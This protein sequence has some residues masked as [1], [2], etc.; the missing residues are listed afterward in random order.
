MA[1]LEFTDE[2]FDQVRREA[3]QLFFGIGK[4]QCPYFQDRVHFNTEGFRHLL[5]KQWNRGRDR[6][7]QFI[8]RKH[9]ARAPEILRLSRTVQGIQETTAW[10]RRRRHGRWENDL[11]AV[12]Y[13]E[14]VAVLN[15]RR[16]KVIV[17]RLPGGERI[18]WSL[19]PFWR[20][21]EQ[22]KRQLHSGDLAEE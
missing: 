4:I 15:S 9:L 3:E 2:E 11:I 14:F 12:S 18:F 21:N 16:F 20:R 22:G 8:R 7:D 10:E 17:K 13:Y 6:R 19:V 1:G 5:F